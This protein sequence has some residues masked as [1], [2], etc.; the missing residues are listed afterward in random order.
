MKGP[1]QLY[2]INWTISGD[3]SSDGECQPSEFDC[4]WNPDYNLTD[5]LL[6][7]ANDATQWRVKRTEG[8]LVPAVV[9]ASNCSTLTLTVANA[10]TAPTLTA[11]TKTFST[12]PA[13]TAK[14]KV[15]HGV[16]QY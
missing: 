8:K 13:L 15:I 3:T 4:E 5:G 14:A 11:V 10:F 2:G 1:G 6:L 7:T 9:A 16:L 12:K